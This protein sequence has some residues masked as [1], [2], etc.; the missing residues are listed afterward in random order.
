MFALSYALSAFRHPVL[1]AAI[2]SFCVGIVLEL[3][4][5]FDFI[6]GTFDILDI[7]FEL[8]AVLIAV[9]IKKRRGTI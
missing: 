7:I 2:I 6:A 4:Q 1:A 8:A 5:L 9:G 3:L